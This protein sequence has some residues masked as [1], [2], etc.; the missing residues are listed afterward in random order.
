MKDQEH[1]FAMIAQVTFR[2]KDIKDALNKLGKHFIAVSKDPN[3]PV[4]FEYG[5]FQLMP[6]KE[7]TESPQTHQNEAQGI[8]TPPH[9]ELHTPDKKRGENGH[10]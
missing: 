2:A 8:I 7:A 4:L 3:T 9:A 10:I 6:V 5:K 1:Q